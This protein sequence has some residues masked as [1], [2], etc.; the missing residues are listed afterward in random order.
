[1][2]LIQMAQLRSLEKFEM[3][4]IDVCK[5]EDFKEKLKMWVQKKKEPLDVYGLKKLKDKIEKH[6][7]QMA[8]R[9]G[10]A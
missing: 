6:Q 8:K 2:V 7:R 9:N 3:N 10:N 1:M 5:D 4:A